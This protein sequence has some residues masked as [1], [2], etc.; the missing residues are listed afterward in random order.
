MNKPIPLR[1]DPSAVRNAALEVMTRAAIATARAE[2]FNDPDPARV[3]RQLWPG[4]KATFEFV[5][6]AASSFATAADA[7]WA[8]PLA[9]IRVEELL[10]NLGPLSI[11]S[12]LL[13]KGITLS[14]GNSHQIRVP[15][16]TV[17]ANYASFVG[18]GKPIPVH[19]LSVSPGAILT[20]SKFAT[21]VALTREMI[22]S[23]NAEPLV[24]AVLV[25]AVAAALDVALLG[26]VAADATRPAGLLYGVTPIGAATGGGVGAMWDDLAA[27][28]TAVAPLGGADIV[29]VTSPGDWV[30]ITFAA[31][32]QFRIPV[33]ASGG[34][35]SK[36]VIAL[37]PSAL[38]S[39]TDP[40][41]RIEASRDAMQHMED[42]NPADPMLP[43]GV[44]I[45]SMFQAD[46][47]SIKLT[48][49][50]SWATRAAGAIAY[51]QNVSW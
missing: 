1:P 34:V 23:S 10:T 45:K 43:A 9:T 12:R 4:D 25:D 48:M 17:S 42:V 41:P 51:V 32:P 37:A 40:A 24:R 21:I 30:K 49:L 19:Q 36:T 15:G 27:L 33:Y 50:V 22:V 46:S 11:G 3:A 26:N 29:Y 31:G 2:L 44:P 16:I 20:P 8:G 7:A 38:C 6:R 28:A 47:V 13:Q 14:F 5:Q 39:A 18:E 35:P